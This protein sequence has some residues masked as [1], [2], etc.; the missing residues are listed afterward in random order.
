MDQASKSGFP[1]LDRIVGELEF[2]CAVCGKSF[3]GHSMGTLKGCFQKLAAAKRELAEKALAALNALKV[4]D[5]F[6]GH[7][8]NGFGQCKGGALRELKRVFTESGVEVEGSG[9]NAM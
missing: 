8:R 2:P 7:W 1:E 9:P 4:D 5:R 3:G 6:S